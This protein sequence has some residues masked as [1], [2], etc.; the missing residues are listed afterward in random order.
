MTD[1][2]Q[3]I[4]RYLRKANIKSALELQKL[5]YNG[6]GFSEDMYRRNRELKDFLYNNLYRHHRV[7][8]MAAK[9]EMIISRIFEM[10]QSNPAALPPE[11]QDRIEEHGLERSICD[12]I[13]GMTD[14]FAIDEYHRLFNVDVL[15]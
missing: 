5:P 15:P 2:I 7:V 6:V 4:D 8:R 14:R 13:A 3:S 12:Y 1:L 10:Y 9:A 11:V